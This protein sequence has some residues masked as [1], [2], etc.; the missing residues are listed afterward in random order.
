MLSDFFDTMGTVFGLANEG[1]IV[2]ENGEVPHFESILVVDSVGAIA[3]GVAGTSS[4][5]SYIESASGIGDGARRVAGGRTQRRDDRLDRGSPRAL[6]RAKP[7]AD[8]L[9]VH[10]LEA[11]TRGVDVGREDLEPQRHALVAGHRLQLRRGKG[12]VLRVEAEPVAGARGDL[13]RLVQAQPA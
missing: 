2:E 6:D 10:R 8:A 1:E 3:G 12:V 5:T 11:I 7:V 4:N 9:H 13:L